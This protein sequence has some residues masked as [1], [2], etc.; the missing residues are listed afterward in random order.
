MFFLKGI[1]FLYFSEKLIK[2][3]MRVQENRMLFFRL[4]VLF[5]LIREVFIT[6]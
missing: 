2:E 6:S 1:S 4:N 3:I 5:F